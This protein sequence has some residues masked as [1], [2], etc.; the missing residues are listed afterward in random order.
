MDLNAYQKEHD[1]KS[2]DIVSAL[3]EKFPKY[4]KHIHSKVLRPSEYGIGLIREAQQIVKGIPQ[5][6]AQKPRRAENRKNPCR[7]QFR[8]NKTLFKRLQQAQKRSGYS[9]MQDFLLYIVKTWME[10]DK[11]DTGV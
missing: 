6:T 1:I 11:N 8:V 10:S 9:T 2:K 7:C 4:D 3:Q 5:E